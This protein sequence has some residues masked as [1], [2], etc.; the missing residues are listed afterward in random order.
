[1]LDFTIAIVRLCLQLLLCGI[2]LVRGI[3]STLTVISIVTDDALKYTV[4][5]NDNRK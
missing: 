4:N 5:N 3:F 1:M 2:L